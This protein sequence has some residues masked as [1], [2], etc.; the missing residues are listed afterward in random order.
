MKILHTESSPGWGGQ[1][2]R[3][4]QEAHTLTEWGHEVW[5][6]CP[7]HALLRE[8]AQAVGVPVVTIPMRGSVD[9]RALFALRRLLARER[10]DV[11]HTHSGK[12]SWIASVAARVVP[13]RPAIVRTRHLALPVRNRVTYQ[14]LPDQVI[15]VSTYVRDYLV[16][17]KGVSPEKVVA[18]PTGVD[19]K[20]FDPGQKGRDLCRELNLPVG[21]PLVGTVGV[22]RYKK[23]HAVLIKAAARVLVRH[24]QTRFLFIGEGPQ[25]E[26]LRRL[27]ASS[28]LAERVILL[29][30]QGDVPELLASLTLFV[31]PS[32]QEAL[33]TSILEAMA[34]AKPTV[35]AAV[36]GIPEAIV[37]G[38]TGL[39]VPPADS[40]ALAEAI[41][42]LL[43]DPPRAR[44]MGEAGRARVEEHFTLERMVSQTLRLY[45]GLLRERGR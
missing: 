32:L 31:L 23:G 11:V 40:E 2:N 12:D 18:I 7:P 19:L 45:Q 21:T 6:A 14:V 39:L 8:K 34:V 4:L 17:E 28:G 29:G 16:Q 25:E 33:G 41:S 38:V 1:E 5:V 24:P 22:L 43:D 27:I 13:H 10:F 3:I 15:T 37:D 35:A 30:A 26:N 20:R 9:P 42:R 44:R 36:G